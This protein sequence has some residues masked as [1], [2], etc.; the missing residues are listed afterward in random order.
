ML[1]RQRRSYLQN[2]QQLKVE[3]ATDT[4]KG[5]LTEKSWNS[6]QLGL[7]TYEV[8]TNIGL[9]ITLIALFLFPTDKTY[10]TYST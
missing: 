9:I 1:S 10:N 8:C 2:R 3:K 6:V 5:R 4:V 7:E